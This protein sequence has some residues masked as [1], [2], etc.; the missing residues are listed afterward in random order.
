MIFSVRR[1]GKLS[2]C[3]ASIEDLGLK[4]AVVVQT[5]GHVDWKSKGA[6]VSNGKVEGGLIKMPADGTHV[7]QDLEGKVGDYSGD[8]IY[9]G[10]IESVSLK[11]LS[12]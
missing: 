1:G 7:G 8:H 5:D 10:Q 3:D 6:S 9:D 2:T 11:I 4:F 12:E